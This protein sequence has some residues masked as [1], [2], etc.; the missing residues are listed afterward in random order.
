MIFSEWKLHSLLVAF[1]LRWFMVLG[2][3]LIWFAFYFKQH[4]RDHHRI[5]IYWH[6]VKT[7]DTVVFRYQL[8]C[9][10]WRK[11]R[12]N[13]I[14]GD[15]ELSKSF[16]FLCKKKH[17]VHLWGS[18]CYNLLGIFNFFL[19]ISGIFPKVMKIMKKKGNTTIL[20][21][22]EF[23]RISGIFFRNFSIF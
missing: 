8:L 7:I 5:W 17:V 21:K 11:V 15:L 14:L 3:E 2:V 20:K 18:K 9:L 1:G 10:V 23:L 16:C 19:G 6:N 12:I 22:K 4:R 13:K